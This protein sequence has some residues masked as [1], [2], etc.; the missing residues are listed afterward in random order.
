[1]EFC[2]TTIIRIF[3][4]VALGSVL[5]G[6][7]AIALFSHIGRDKRERLITVSAMSALLTAWL[8]SIGATIGL[9]FLPEGS[10]DLLSITLCSLS[11]HAVRIELIFDRLAA[12]FLVV[13]YSLCGIASAFSRD[14][15]HRDKGQGRFYFLVL[16]FSLGMSVVLLAR[17]IPSMYV[18][19][20]VIGLTSA[21]LISFFH[22]R[23]ATREN[24]LRA[25][26]A[27]RLSDTSLLLAGLLIG[28]G[29]SSHGA[30][31][32]SPQI[33]GTANDIVVPLL[34][35]LAALPKSAQIP[36]SAWLP[37]A[38]EGPTPSSAIFYGGLSVHAGLYLLLR[39]RQLMV[40]SDWLLIPIFVLGAASAIIGTMQASVQTDIKGSLA[41]ASMAQVGLMFVELALGFHQLVILHFIGHSA[42]RTY[43]ILSAN[44]SLHEGRLRRRSRSGKV[45][46]VKGKFYQIA[47]LTSLRDGTGAHS[48]VT[49]LER[50]SLFLG[51]IESIFTANL[52]RVVSKIF[53]RKR[54]F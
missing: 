29:A 13:T 22:E 19:W 25:F 21:L 3:C 42:V 52:S 40:L 54:S 20:E 43:Q 33:G 8:S 37:R 12:P 41:F 45:S 44:S 1:M 51:E 49:S 4:L 23:G 2:V 6:V 34:I 9:I 38:M 31:H 11:D 46:S 39:S 24:A 48:L 50:I 47:F 15:L 18:G 16:L 28:F 14:Y 32:L 30:S 35:L 17:N 5:I 7:L 36:F 10:I 26:W 27:Y 53:G